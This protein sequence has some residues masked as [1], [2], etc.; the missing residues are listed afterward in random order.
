VF[1][2]DDEPFAGK[3]A[4]LKPN[5]GQNVQF[6]SCR[7]RL[8]G[9]NLGDLTAGERPAD[10]DPK[11]DRRGLGGVERLE[12]AGKVSLEVLDILQPDMQ[13]QGRAAR[14]P[15]GGRSIGCAVERN[16]K[17]FEAAP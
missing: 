4:E 9:W 2:S 12:P 15:V 3:A 5:Q 17:A 10:D 13:P 16:D 8:G 1:G 7:S 6:V 11:E 14:R